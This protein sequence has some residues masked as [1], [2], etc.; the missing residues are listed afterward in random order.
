M[1]Y[2]YTTDPAHMPRNH[3]EF[4][5][6]DPGQLL[7]WA[8]SVGPHAAALMERIMKRSPI[9][10]QGW[11]SGRGLRRLGEKYGAARTEEACRRAL[12]CGSHGQR[13]VA[14]M[15]KNGLDLRPLPDEVEDESEVIHHEQ[16]R[17]PEYYN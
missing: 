9:A 7:E 14:L 4:Y 8:A 11:R 10:L 6:K 16:V 1:P 5:D 13:P 17:G 15:L 12:L 2:S 3:R